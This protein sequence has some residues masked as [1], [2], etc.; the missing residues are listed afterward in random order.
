GRAVAG[1]WKASAGPVVVVASGAGGAKNA[2]WPPRMPR[3]KRG[4]LGRGWHPWGLNSQFSRFARTRPGHHPPARR[5]V[6]DLARRR[7]G[8]GASPM[9]R[10]LT[11]AEHDPNP[12]DPA[13]AAALAIVPPGFP[14]SR[15]L[16]PSA[17][18]A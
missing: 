18:P 1:G 4:I 16:L 12:Y 2:N 15:P 9:T 11:Q 3:S 14:K 8:S 5:A 10:P 6:R 7:I 17:R 13:L